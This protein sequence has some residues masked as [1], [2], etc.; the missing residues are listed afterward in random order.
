MC[1]IIYYVLPTIE[2]VC[3]IFLIHDVQDIII[4]IA[5]ARVV[6]DKCYL[7]LVMTAVLLIQVEISFEPYTEQSIDCVGQ[8]LKS[9]VNSSRS[10]QRVQ[11]FSD[12]IGDVIF[13]LHICAIKG[14]RITWNKKY[15]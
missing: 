14:P 4:L 5:C 15:M 13:Q 7:W 3:M 11:P 9:P 10:A 6:F 2:C 1:A 12:Y 8:S